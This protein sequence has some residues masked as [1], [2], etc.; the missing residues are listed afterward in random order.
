MKTFLIKE[1]SNSCKHNMDQAKENFL[2]SQKTSSDEWIYQLNIC[3]NY[4]EKLFFFNNEFC[5]VE[6]PSCLQRGEKDCDFVVKMLQQL[7][8]VNNLPLNLIDKG[9]VDDSTLRDFR[10]RG[11][12]IERDFTEINYLYSNNAGKTW[13]IT[14]KKP[15]FDVL[16]YNDI[17]EEDYLKMTEF[18][19]K[20]DKKHLLKNLE[21]ILLRNKID[22]SDFEIIKTAE[23]LSKLLIQKTK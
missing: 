17:I 20:H 19:K 11:I 9:I 4:N 18:L 2:N 16:N 6:Y 22:I 15:W 12:E 14:T 7:K 5:Y 8:E 10:I 21:R 13:A 3:R 23:H 1:H